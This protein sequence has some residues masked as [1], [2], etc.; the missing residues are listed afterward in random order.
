MPR[1][2]PPRALDARAA[3]LAAADLL[4]RRAWTRRDLA[5][6]LRRRGAP[7]E[8]AV[9]V[10]DDLAGRGY[11]DDATFARHWVET[12]ASRGYGA[13]RLRSELLARG[14]AAALVD[15]ALASIAPDAV[16][17]AARE[18]ARKRLPALHR[19]AAA[20]VAARLSDH[21]LRR[22]F[23]GAIVARVVREVVGDDGEP[24]D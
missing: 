16:A 3:R 4:S 19:G 5:A 22:G 18:A 6:R 9:A 2:R 11:V 1:P 13:N 23:P 8:I 21:L 15:E 24:S 7:A 12:R 10:V 14:V 20:R 17:A